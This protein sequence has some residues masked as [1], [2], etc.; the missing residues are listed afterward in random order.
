MIGCCYSTERYDGRKGG[1]GERQAQMPGLKSQKQGGPLRFG[2]LAT[3]T[4]CAHVASSL[5]TCQG[6]VFKHGELYL[7]N[8]TAQSTGASEGWQKIVMW[9]SDSGSGL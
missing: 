3:Q 5:G 2:D 9:C 7:N 8:A 6:E 4:C 1:R